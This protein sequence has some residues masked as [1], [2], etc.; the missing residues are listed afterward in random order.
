MDANFKDI[1]KVLKIDKKVP[2][3]VQYYYFRGRSN[4]FFV[5]KEITISNHSQIITNIYHTTI[6]VIKNYLLIL[7]YNSIVHSTLTS[8]SYI[9]IPQRFVARMTEKGNDTT[10]K[11]GLV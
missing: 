9:N 1:G 8:V 2:N 5:A 6:E 7:T 10:S 11:R 4:W 3:L